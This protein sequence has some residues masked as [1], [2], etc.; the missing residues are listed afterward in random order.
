MRKMENSTTKMIT[1][2]ILEDL[3]ASFV[4]LGNPS[5]IIEKEDH[6]G[7]LTIYQGD[8]EFVRGLEKCGEAW[9]VTYDEAVIGEA[10]E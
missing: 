3:I 7:T 8:R 5:I 4:N 2:K 10:R 1:S 6:A 9:V